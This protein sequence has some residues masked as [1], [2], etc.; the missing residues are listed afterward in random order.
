M[1]FY[2]DRHDRLPFLSEQIMGLGSR[3]LHWQRNFEG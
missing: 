1:P 2:N 3:M